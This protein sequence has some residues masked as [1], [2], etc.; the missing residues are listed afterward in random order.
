MPASKKPVTC[1]HLDRP[2]YGHG[3]CHSCYRKNTEG[4]ASKKGELTNCEVAFAKHLRMVLDNC[5]VNG[6]L[7]TITDRGIVG[8]WHE[9]FFDWAA[10]VRY[11]QKHPDEHNLRSFLPTQKRKLCFLGTAEDEEI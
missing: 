10:A 2:N 3:L 9:A 6:D 1:G 11:G 4:K 8:T 7:S 5:R